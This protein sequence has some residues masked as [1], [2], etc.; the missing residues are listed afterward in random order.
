MT[1]ELHINKRVPAAEVGLGLFGFWSSSPCPPCHTTP[2]PPLLQELPWSPEQLGHKA[3]QFLP[4]VPPQSSWGVKAVVWA[5]LS[6][7]G[8][9]TAA[10][11]AVAAA[12]SEP[13]PQPGEAE[14]RE[15]GR[16]APPAHLHPPKAVGRGYEPKCFNLEGCFNRDWEGSARDPE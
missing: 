14:G 6:P 4:P 13:A 11:I 7:P 1:P 8:V 15:L 12:G 2:V 5:R 10:W 16:D 9:P 3:P